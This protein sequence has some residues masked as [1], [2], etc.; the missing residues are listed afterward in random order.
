MK[1]P[2]REKAYVP[3]AKV[4]DYLL[5]EKHPKGWSKAKLLR[6]LGHD[7]R[8]IDII[9]QNLLDIA[10][11]Q[12][13]RDTYESRYGISYVLDGFLQTPSGVSVRFRTVWCIDND[14]ERPRFVTGYPLVLRE[15]K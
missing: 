12:E 1:L 2:H 6:A 8:T 4:R 10:Y 9:I 15:R 7:D 14:A 5:A 13:V 3:I 11:S